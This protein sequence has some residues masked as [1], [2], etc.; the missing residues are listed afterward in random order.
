MVKQRIRI[1]I[2]LIFSILLVDILLIKADDNEAIMLARKKN[3]WVDSVMA[4]MS[5]MERVGQLFMVSA[6]SNRNEK[7]V[8]DLENLIRNYNIGG[9]IFF[10][11][12]P[13]RQAVITNRLQAQSR[14]PMLIGMDAEWGLSMRLD[15]TWSFPRQMALGAQRTSQGTYLVGLEMAR[16][17]RRMGVH[18]SFSPDIDVN[19]NPLNP[20][21]G[22]RSFGEDVELVTDRGIAYMKGL[23]DHGVLASAKH[24][25][26]HG[27]AAADSHYDLPLISRSRKQLD[28]VEL[29]PFKAL[30]KAGVKTVMVGHLYVPAL[31]TTRNRPTSISKKVVTDLL[32]DDLGFR[33]ITM[34]DALNMKGAAAFAKPG[35]LEILALKAGH[36]ILLCPDNVPVAFNAIK[37]AI[38]KGE[39]DQYDID[40]KVRRIIEA[41]FWAGL[42]QY[43][44][45]DLNQLDQD[46]MPASLKRLN[47]SLYAQSATVINKV[48]DFLPIRQIE[49]KELVSIAIQAD[50]NGDY[51]QLMKRYAP[52]R[53]FATPEK[54]PS[55]IIWDSLR[56]QV[57]GSRKTIIV[58][59]HNLQ[60]K[61]KN[62]NLPDSGIALVPQLKAQGHEVVVVA[63]G[64]AYSLKNFPDVE[65]L[66][67]LYEDNSYTR[68]L[69]P[70]ILFGSLA[71]EGRLP[72]SAR[73]GLPRGSGE[74]TPAL[75][76]LDYDEP[77]AV[78]MSSQVL[79]R[80]DTIAREM[81]SQRM[82]PGAQV[83]IA[84]QGKVVYYKTFGRMTY[85]STSAAVRD[86]TRYD[87]ASISKVA[88][89][90][91]AIM[92]LEGQRKIN[93]A[94]PVKNYLPEL[95][96][97]NKANIIVQDLLLHRAGLQPFLPFW[98]RTMLNR[99]LNTLWYCDRP[100]D[101][102]STQVAPKLFTKG[103]TTDSIWAWVVKSELL[104]PNREG[105]FDT[106]YSDFSFLFL[107]EIVERI[108]GKPLDVFLRDEFFKPLGTNLTYQ[109]L[110]TVSPKLIAPTEV[111]SVWRGGLIT[112]TVHDQTAALMGGVAGHAGL[113][114]TANDL[115]ILLEMNKQDGYYGGKR[116][117]DLGQVSKFTRRFASSVRGLGWDKPPVDKREKAPVSQYA[118]PE[119]YGHTGFTGNC[120]WV[121]PVYDLTFIFLSN[122]VYPDAGNVKI[123][124]AQIRGRIHDVAYEA[125]FKNFPTVTAQVPASIKPEQ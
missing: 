83:L 71:A 36:D 46:L 54:N 21:I 5:P 82:A 44:P 25:P 79:Q 55:P 73:N 101:Q 95:E 112:G 15:S 62:F 45:I 86:V 124:K 50:T 72:V 20:V 115:A 65:A 68:T 47:R 9:L 41:K 117:L 120:V 59:F 67:T 40:Q 58:S 4:T 96:G 123:S 78:G 30:I 93:L 111:D 110:R 70:Q 91:Q 19:S 49:T 102:F 43:K 69:A 99:Q 60:S 92:L 26:G 31:D 119:T 84:R 121:D 106:K 66:V 13:K 104:P 42:N 1:T 17:C 76:R 11:G 32:I 38:E 29:R 3:R 10:Q 14:I 77:E 61:A 63:F 28:S 16:Q 64:N 48:T 53:C 118:S 33:G 116:Y 8:Q 105:T 113:F 24:F 81:I 90:L 12:G 103:S 56:R 125:L 98:K 51:Q 107:Q 34:T 87:L 114:G 6:Y 100:E 109:P 27:D 52:I 122:R 94:D 89:T 37:R 85:D 35:E 75:A 2:G 80:I 39:L 57:S 23:Q 74:Q 97:T 18:I 22:F 88:G 108:T 7:H